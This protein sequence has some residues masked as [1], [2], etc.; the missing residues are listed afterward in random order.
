MLGLE[1]HLVTMHKEIDRFKPQ[2]VI[3]DPI[4]DFEAIGS[5]GAAKAMLLRIVDFLKARQITALFTSLTSEDAAPGSSEVGISSLIDTWL[6]LRNIEQSGERNRGLY[7]LKSRGMAHS[8]QIREFILTDHGAKLLDVAVG[9]DGVITGSARLAQLA[10]EAS[11]AA[12]REQVGEAKRRSLAHKRIALQARLKALQAEFDA[13]AQSLEL[14]I[15]QDK[16]REQREQAERARLVQ[17]RTAETSP[18]RP[19]K[20][21]AK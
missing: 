12:D 15:E 7:V 2:N 21:G 9:T 13:E 11:G 6:L 10:R 3:M 19:V 20:G 1:M 14:E 4:T 8:N 16:L 17:A 18:I 5:R